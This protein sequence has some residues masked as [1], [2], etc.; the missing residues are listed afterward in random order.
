MKDFNLKNYLEENKL[1][2]ELEVSNV[3][4]YVVIPFYSDGGRLNDNEVMVFK[5]YN[6]ADDYKEGLEGKVEII[7]TELK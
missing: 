7:A 4:V 2:K 6:D 3:K 1:L 5:N